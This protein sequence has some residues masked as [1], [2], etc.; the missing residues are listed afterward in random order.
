MP[1][2]NLFLK[3]GSFAKRFSPAFY[4]GLLANDGE[5]TLQFAFDK[6]LF[7]STFVNKSAK[8]SFAAP[9]LPTVN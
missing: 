5:M 6:F 9:L 8:N 4:F 3:K 2:L 7:S 1:V